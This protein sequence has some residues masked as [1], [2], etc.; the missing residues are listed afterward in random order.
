MH[1]WSLKVLFGASAFG[2]LVLMPLFK[3]AANYLECGKFSMQFTLAYTADSCLIEWAIA[4][5]FTLFVGTVS[6]FICYF[7]ARSNE[8]FK[9]CGACIQ[10]DRLTSID[11]ELLDLDGI[12]HPKL[13]QGQSARAVSSAPLSPQE[14]EQRIQELRHKR[15]DAQ[16]TDA[17]YESQ[18]AVIQSAIVE[19]PASQAQRACGWFSLM[20]IWLLVMLVYSVPSVLYCLTTAVPPDENTYGLGSGKQPLNCYLCSSDYCAAGTLIA[21][22]YFIG[23][24]LHGISSWLLPNTARWV[25]KL[26]IKPNEEVEQRLVVYARVA[27]I[28]VIPL[29][30]VVW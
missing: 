3:T 28:L 11:V 17:D 6:I 30:S 24:L 8:I 23:P 14:A 27:T 9:D 19:P 26:T 29:L 7:E 4:V 5:L 25:T 22:H 10:L 15:K 20:V 21:F 16:L 13:G 12:I 1:V 2:V 18:K